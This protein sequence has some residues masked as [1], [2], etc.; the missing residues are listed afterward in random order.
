MDEEEHRPTDS[1]EFRIYLTDGSLG[2]FIT[3]DKN[4]ILNFGSGNYFLGEA[5]EKGNYPEPDAAA[6]KPG[7]FVTPAP[8]DRS[9][10]NEWTRTKVE[11]IYTVPPEDYE[12]MVGEFKMELARYKTTLS[13]LE[14]E[15]GIKI[16][17][18]QLIISDLERERDDKKGKLE[19]P[20]SI[21]DRMSD[22]LKL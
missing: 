6:F 22:Y 21:E 3:D 10:A 7:D 13:S 14:A 1:K 8:F 2:M 9:W 4:T 15:A 19:E 18:L 20:K 16:N 17:T 5:K 12:R 11:M